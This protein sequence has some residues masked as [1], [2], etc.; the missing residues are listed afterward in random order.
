MVHGGLILYC[1]R[2]RK[3]V[4]CRE[5]TDREQ[6]TEKQ[7]TEATLIQMDRR[8]KW[9]N[10]LFCGDKVIQRVIVFYFELKL[11]PSEVTILPLG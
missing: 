5:Q 6:R 7:I 11:L 2:I 10:T 9:A 8:V 4:T 1:S 3:N